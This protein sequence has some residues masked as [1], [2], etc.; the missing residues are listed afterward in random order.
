IIASLIT[1]VS[2]AFTGVIGFIGLIIPHMVRLI[3]GP[4][5]RILLPVS[6]FTGASFLILADVLAKTIIFPVE[7][8]V[9]I[10]T[11]FCGAPFF[12]YLLRK[13]KKSTLIA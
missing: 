9:G 4:D 8:P 11:A 1:G 6:A 12:L 2:V 5:H 13:H 3:T 10:I 7:I